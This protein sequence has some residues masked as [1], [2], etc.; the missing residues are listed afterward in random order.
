MTYTGWPISQ[1]T[2]KKLNISITARSNG[3][4]F[5]PRIEACL[6]SKSIRIRLVRTFAKDHYR[7]EQE[8]FTFSQVRRKQYTGWCKTHFIEK[9]N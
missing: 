1:V 6:H 9:E 5:L 2:E 7:P 8:K 4:I 3:L